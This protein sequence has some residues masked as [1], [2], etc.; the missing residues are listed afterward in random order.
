M[1]E[2]F[3]VI[4]VLGLEDLDRAMGPVVMDSAL[5]DLSGRIAL[6]TTEVLS[7]TQASTAAQT[8]RRGCWRASF[9]LDSQSPV[10]GTIRECIDSI[11]AATQQ[12]AN[13]AALEIFGPATAALASVTVACIERVSIQTEYDELRLKANAAFD[14]GSQA[15]IQLIIHR[16]LLRTVFQP[17]VTLPDGKTVGVEALSRGPAGSPYESADKLFGAAAR[18]GLTHTL[19]LACAIQALGCLDRLPEPLW[20]S[21]N[22]S[23]A[24]ASALYSHICVNRIDC[25]RLILEMTEHL[26]LRKIDDLRPTLDGLRS[27]GARIAL[28]DTGCGYA[29]LEAAT[30]I[31][32]DIV[33]LCITVIGRVE[34]HKDVRSA[35]AETVKRS[36]S[37]GTLMLAEGVE[38]LDQAHILSGLG[39]ELAQGWLYGKP[40]PAAELTFRT[41]TVLPCQT[42]PL[43]LVASA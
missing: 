1:D 11:S 37:R 23:A 33:K 8:L 32:A 7:L 43:P 42:A 29:D 30:R 14:A 16:K 20:M 2:Y 36:R 34:Q 3:L 10:G 35:I 5:A 21:I 26:P 39:I 22:V 18:S 4:E 6:L 13:D 40:F 9:S 41:Q 38:T 15:A 28:D 24:T 19:E 25:S 31:E 27:R 17:I 12:L